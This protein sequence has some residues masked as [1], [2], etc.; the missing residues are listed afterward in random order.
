MLFLVCIPIV[1][2][3]AKLPPPTTPATSEPICDGGSSSRFG[4]MTCQNTDDQQQLTSSS[5]TESIPFYGPT[6][7]KASTAI[8]SVVAGKMD[9]F[10]DLQTRLMQQIVRP[11]KDRMKEAFI[12]Y[13][14]ESVYEIHPSL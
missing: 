11:N 1:Q 13:L 6:T 5:T 8:S 14:K 10:M 2:L 9:Q 4:Q 7:S 12:D 3:K